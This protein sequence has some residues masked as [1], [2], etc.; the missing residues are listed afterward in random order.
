MK[1]GRHSLLNSILHQIYA[2]M[3][4]QVDIFRMQIA[5]HMVKYADELIGIL[6]KFLEQK[7]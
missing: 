1:P 6:D 2:P 3:A 7:N 4:Y 5:V